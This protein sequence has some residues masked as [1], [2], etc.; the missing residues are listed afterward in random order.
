[1]ANLFTER[2]QN[3]TVFPTVSHSIRTNTER[4]WGVQRGS[5]LCI[6]KQQYDMIRYYEIGKAALAQALIS[7]ASIPV[8]L[9]TAMPLHIC[10]VCVRVYVR[11]L[12][13]QLLPNGN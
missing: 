9:S 13:M 11:P 12:Q 1:M 2:S 8:P 5:N 3:N 10:Y 4:L 6:M 7:E